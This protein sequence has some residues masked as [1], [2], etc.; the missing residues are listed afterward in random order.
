MVK[1]SAGSS[2]VFSL[3]TQYEFDLTV[4]PPKYIS[5]TWTELNW[6][7]IDIDIEIYYIAIYHYIEIYYLEN[8]N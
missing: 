1:P 4:N 2:L 7:D 5:V 3:V 6:P 8:R